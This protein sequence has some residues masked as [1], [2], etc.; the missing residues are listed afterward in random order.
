[1]QDMLTPRE[2]GSI[3]DIPVP[4]NHHR[5]LPPIDTP[6]RQRRGRSWLWIVLGVIIACATAGLL[7]ST[8]FEAAQITLYPKTQQVSGPI[9]LTA[10]P[11]APAGA[12]GYQIVTLNATASTTATASGSQQVSTKASGLITIYNAYSTASQKLITNTRFEAS[13]GNIY[14]IRTGVTVPGGTKQANGNLTP[15]SV[16]ITVYADQPGASYNITAPTTFT[17]PGFQNSALYTAFSAQSQGP[18]SGGFVGMQAAVSTADLAT[19][20]AVLTQEL[21]TQLQSVASSSVPSGS[22]VVQNSLSTTYDPPIQSNTNGTTVTLSQHAT[23]LEAAVSASDVAAAVATQAAQGYQGGAIAFASPSQV[24]VTLTNTSSS[25]PTGP[26][27]L[28]VSGSLNLVWQFDQNAIKQALVGQ[29]KSSFQKIIQNFEPAVASA[30]ASVRP[31]W[32]G[33][34]PSDP[35]KIKITIN[36]Q[37]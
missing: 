10:Q 9:T 23:A 15:G 11:D 5:P 2:R 28:S 22:F 26:L 7:L 16:T 19:A 27:T 36:S 21:D 35:N 1:M 3:R 20:Q 8:V 24:S 32:R 13:N 17:I 29:P 6:R 18:I 25:A 37:S 12:L 14:R 30:S 33:T 31:F 4:A 34:F